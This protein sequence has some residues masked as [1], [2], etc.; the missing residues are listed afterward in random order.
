MYKNTIRQASVKQLDLGHPESMRT[1]SVNRLGPLAMG[2]DAK[3]NALAGPSLEEVI[4]K[5]KMSQIH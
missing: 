2:T 1:S 5:G 4:E 3:D